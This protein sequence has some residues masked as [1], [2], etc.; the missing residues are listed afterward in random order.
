[1]RQR[2]PN[3]NANG[4][5]MTT[6]THTLTKGRKPS[7]CARKSARPKVTNEF[8]VGDSRRSS[9]TSWQ[10]MTKEIHEITL[11]MIVGGTMER[12]KG[13]LRRGSIFVGQRLKYGMNRMA[14]VTVQS[15]SRYGTPVRQPVLDKEYGS[16]LPTVRAVIDKRPDIVRRNRGAPNNDGTRDGRT[17]RATC[18]P[19]LVVHG[20]STSDDTADSSHSRRAHRNHAIKFG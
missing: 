15:Q 19:H 10:N 6:G 8:S 5:V 17:L 7:V 16:A 1:M 2:R 9:A 13:C 4:V 18:P 11:T 12:M 3:R 20:Y 14:P